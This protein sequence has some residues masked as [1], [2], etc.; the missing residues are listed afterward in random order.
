MEKSRWDVTEENM[1]VEFQVLTVRGTQ[2]GSRY[3]K[4]MT[5]HIQLRVPYTSLL[6]SLYMVGC[7]T[8][9][10]KS[11]CNTHHNIEADWS[12]F[13]TGC[14][15]GML[16]FPLPIKG[17]FWHTDWVTFFLVTIWRKTHSLKEYSH[18]YGDFFV[19]CGTFVCLFEMSL[20]HCNICISMRRFRKLRA[21]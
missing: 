12:D 4:V 18:D 11:F 16:L 13:K 7:T 3:Q 10:P 15:W 6:T 9:P 14:F 8:F 21:K 17:M 19:V 20:V 2:K 5:N 1:V